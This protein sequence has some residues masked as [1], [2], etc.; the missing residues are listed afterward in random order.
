MTLAAPPRGRHD[1]TAAA[2]RQVGAPEPSVLRRTRQQRRTAGASLTATALAGLGALLLGFVAEVA[3][4]GAVRHGRDQ[5]VAFTRLRLELASGTT[6]LGALDTNG[7]PVVAGAPVALLE[8]PSA[9]VKE[10]VLEG[11]SSGVLRSGP[12]HRRDTVL[13]GQVGTSVVMGRRGAYGG[14]FRNL[15][16]L[17]PGQDLA[18]TTGQGRLRFR[19]LDVRVA[20]DPEPPPLAAGAARLTLVTASGPAFVPGGVLLVDADL[21]GAGLA[22]PAGLPVVGSAEQELGTDSA[23]LVPLVLWLQAL[24]LAACGVTWARHGW[25]R[26]QAWLVGAPVLT[27]IAV[28]AADQAACLLPNLL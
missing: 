24:V 10:V 5:E 3:V 28:S 8:V 23:A 2:V 11:T 12:G 9:G 7:V 22:A 14:P 6:P 1:A 21:V 16:H 17:R 25:G 15:G 26:W 27:W 18:V 4:L 19:V 20:G 13:P